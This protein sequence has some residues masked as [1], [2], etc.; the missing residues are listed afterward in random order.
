MADIAEEARAILESLSSE[1]VFGALTLEVAQMEYQGFS[2]VLLLRHMWQMAKAKGLSQDDFKAD[3]RTMAVLGLM[4]GSNTKSI[5]AKSTP[6]A[7]KQIALWEDRYHLT[8]NKPATS[9]TVTLVRVASCLARPMSLAIHSGNLNIEGAV[10]AAS[11]YA[12]YPRG[13]A[14]SSFGSLIPGVDSVSEEVC[15]TLA[16]AFML[17]QYKFDQVINSGKNKQTNINNIKQYTKIQMS[18][19]LY[20]ADVRVQHCVDIGVI[21]RVGAAYAIAPAHAL[22]LR[23]AAAVFNA[24]E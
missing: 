3:T 13:M 18:S 2:P 19:S 12:G 4:R 17:H 5:K 16:S 23:G 7:I 15:S 8:G 6:A 14:I 24:L 1:A 21:A 10:A 11:V 9:T 22:A 20:S